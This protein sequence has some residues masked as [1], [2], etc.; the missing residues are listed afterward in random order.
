MTA[1]G[2]LAALL[3]T[4]TGQ[5]QFVSWI[6]SHITQLQIHAARERAAPVGLFPGDDQIQAAYR[7]GVSVG[8]HGQ[9]E[10]MLN[11]VRQVSRSDSGADNGARNAQGGF[12][13][14]YGAAELI[15]KDEV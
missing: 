9:I 14:D 5:E 8:A 10:A 4:E 13:S 1:Q 15:E 11:P 12:R 2:E 7:L 6:S 3:G